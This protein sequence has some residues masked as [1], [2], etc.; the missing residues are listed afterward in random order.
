MFEIYGNNQAIYLLELYGMCPW[1]CT[2]SWIAGYNLICY[3]Y[4]T[5]PLRQDEGLDRRLVT[6][7]IEVGSSGR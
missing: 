1:Y 7:E 3:S 4:A 2:F 5:K 6:E